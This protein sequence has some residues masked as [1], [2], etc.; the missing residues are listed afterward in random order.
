MFDY[1]KLDEVLE[2]KWF[3]FE[4]NIDGEPKNID[5]LPKKN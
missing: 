1:K 4:K 3:Q 5:P 2:K